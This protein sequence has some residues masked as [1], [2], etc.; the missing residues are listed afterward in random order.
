MIGLPI[1][2]VLI[3]VAMALITQRMMTS[4]GRVPWLGLSTPAVYLG[5]PFMKPCLNESLRHVICRLTGIAKRRKT[6]G[7]AMLFGKYR[8]MAS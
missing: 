4:T 8:S 6:V 3:A 2:A 7:S 5:N 1:L